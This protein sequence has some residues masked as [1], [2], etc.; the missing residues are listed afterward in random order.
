M[1]DNEIP[2]SESLLKFPCDFTIKVIGTKSDE[3][4]STVLM[5][6]HK[7]VPNLSN[8]AIQARPSENGKY[9]ALSITVHIESKDLLDDIYRELSSSPLVL[10]AL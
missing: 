8:R 7:H 3:F 5:I 6:I 10:M 4:E 9:L 1:N 2:P